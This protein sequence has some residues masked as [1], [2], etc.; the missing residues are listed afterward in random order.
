M[1]LLPQGKCCRRLCDD[2]ADNLMEGHPDHE[3]PA[4]DDPRTGAQSRDPHGLAWTAEEWES[5]YSGWRRR[6]HGRWEDGSVG[7]LSTGKNLAE[8]RWERFALEEVE[9]STRRLPSASIPW[10]LPGFQS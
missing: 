1:N 6:R 2:A 3:L 7:G 10:M 9:S 8:T 4:A 5:W